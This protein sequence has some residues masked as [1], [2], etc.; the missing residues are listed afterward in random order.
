MSTTTARIDA[1]SPLAQPETFTVTASYV[2]QA[3]AERA[4]RRPQAGRILARGVPVI[5]AWMDVQSIEDR[6]RDL[7]LTDAYMATQAS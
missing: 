7:A 4:S 6:A 3:Q 1:G 2:A 5:A